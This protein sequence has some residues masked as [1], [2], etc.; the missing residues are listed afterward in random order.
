[1]KFLVQG[2]SYY[3][4][5]PHFSLEIKVVIKIESNP[6]YP[7]IYETFKQKW[8]KIFKNFFE[9]WISEFCCFKKR[10]FFKSTRIPQNWWIWKIDFFWNNK[11][12]IFKI[13][14]KKNCFCLIP[15]QMSHKFF[16]FNSVFMIT[17]ISSKK[18]GGCN[19]MRHPVRV[20]KG[21]VYIWKFVLVKFE[22][23][24]DLW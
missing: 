4:T 1:V 23:A 11:I 14:K 16:G 5:P 13:Q 12:P 6:C 15:V 18:L 22:H 8:G 21:M 9:F 24:K 10:Q 17:L 2:V 3:Y 19:N 7:R 20:I